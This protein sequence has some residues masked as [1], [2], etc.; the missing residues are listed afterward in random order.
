MNR[1]RYVLLAAVSV[2]CTAVMGQGKSITERIYWFDGDYASSASLGA[3]VDI[4]SLAV[5]MHSFTVWVKDSEGVWSS[6]VTRFFVVSAMPDVASE[7]AERECWLDGNIAG[8]TTL[9]PSEAI[10]DLGELG[11]GMHSFSMRVKDDVGVWSAPVTKFFLIE[12]MPDVASEVAER[13]YW[14]DG[15]FAGRSTLGASEAIIDLGEQLP[16]MHSFTMRVRDDVNVWS[17]PVTKYFI[18]DNVTEEATEVAEREYW[19]DGDFANRT[20]LGTSEA[21][22]DLGELGKGM[23][24]FTMRLKNDVGVWSSPVTKYFFIA[25]IDETQ[26]VTLTQYAYWFDDDITRVQNGPLEAA[27]GIIPVSI[28]HLDEGRHALKWT[29]GDSHGHWSAAAVDSFD[30]VHLPLTEMKFDLAER[31]FEYSAEDIEPE[32]TII[33]G[34]ET[35]VRDEDYEILYADNRNAGTATMN[36][37][38]LGFYK[39]SIQTDFTITKAPLT[40]KADDK[41]KEQGEEN[42]ELTFTI[43]GWKGNDDE[44]VLGALPVATTTATADS[45][46]GMYDILINGGEALNYTFTYVSGVLTIEEQVGIDDVSD[47]SADDEWYTLA[48]QKLD[49]KPTKAGIYIHNGRKVLVK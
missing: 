7:V 41:V 5:G 24:S 40:V 39:D 37:R 49:R 6:P 30:V 23:H 4:S 14:L 9:G 31:T 36:V 15:D 35:L 34:D 8:R 47:D 27:S 45:P 19:L 10:V 29:V 20:P 18:I 48:G 32:P 44:S 17:A 33:D 38:G 3:S 28:K 16:G 12:T 46:A 25:P 2:V 42:P 43:E 21:V 11:Q 22:I 26:A 13:E 1:L